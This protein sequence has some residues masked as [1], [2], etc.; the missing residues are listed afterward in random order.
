MKYKGKWRAV[1]AN[2]NSLTFAV[3]PQIVVVRKG[4]PSLSTQMETKFY[5]LDKF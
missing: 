3:N 5:A 4:L 2:A 1:Q